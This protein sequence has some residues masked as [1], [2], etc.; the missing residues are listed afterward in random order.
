LFLKDVVLARV[1]DDSTFNVINSCIIFNQ[2]DIINHVQTER[3]F[4]MQVVEP[5][6]DD[7][8]AGVPWWRERLKELEKARL[9]KDDTMDVDEAAPSS[10]PS[11]S[12]TNEAVNAPRPTWPDETRRSIIQLLQQLCAMGK[13]IQLPAR[14]A[15]FRTLTDRAVLFPVQWAM[16]QDEKDESGR[17][18]IAA[19][20]E[21]L[22][23]LLDHDIHGVRGF[24]LRQTVEVEEGKNAETLLMLM[25]KIVVRSRDLA[26]QSQIGD[27]LKLMLEIPVLDPND[28]SQV[29]L[30]ATILR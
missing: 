12:G 15:L 7:E 9:K 3:N 23:V 11:G 21:I 16:A 29:R 6:L 13:N 4:L 28:T 8:V 26:V 17:Q 14:L 24:I 1:L 19:A 30:F 20:G 22:S 2:I 27:T 18:M 25:C 10:Q 5:F